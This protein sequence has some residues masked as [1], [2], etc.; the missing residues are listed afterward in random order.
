[1]LGVPTRKPAA[2]VLLVSS[3]AWVFR[4]PS[5]VFPEMAT[6]GETDGEKLAVGVKIRPVER[7]R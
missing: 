6:V 4:L 5:A 3:A 1:M 7:T 2:F